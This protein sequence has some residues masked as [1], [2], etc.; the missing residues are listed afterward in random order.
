[1]PYP[2]QM[3]F[4]NLSYFGF[5]GWLA[6]WGQTSHS[7]IFQVYTDGTVVQF[8]NL[9]LQ[10]WAPN[11]FGRYGSWVYRAYPYTGT[12]TSEDVFYLLA[13]RGPTR[14]ES[15]PG[16]EPG[17]PDPQSS[18]LPIRH[19]TSSLKRSYNWCKIWSGWNRSW[20]RLFIVVSPS[21]SQLFCGASPCTSY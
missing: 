19:S 14:S 16:I 20:G 1:M 17:S 6:C 5:V 10:P 18:S 2:S 12:G 11:A 7:A 3:L 13:T 4:R 15:Y 21:G 8:Q 9:D